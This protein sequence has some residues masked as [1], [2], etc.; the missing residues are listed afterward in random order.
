M[1]EAIR[2]RALV[3]GHVILDMPIGVLFQAEV[4]HGR[5][6]PIAVGSGVTIQVIEDDKPVLE[7]HYSVGEMFPMMDAHD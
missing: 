1:K 5:A 3:R 6:Q 2:I 4:I 7:R